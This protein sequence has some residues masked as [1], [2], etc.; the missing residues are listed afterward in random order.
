MI[1]RRLARSPET[2]NRS[3]CATTTTTRNKKKSC[4]SVLG[5]HSVRQ[6]TKFG[7]VSIFVVM[8]G[9]FSLH[10]LER[11]Q[12]LKANIEA[13]ALLESFTATQAKIESAL[14]A[15]EVRACAVCSVQCPAGGWFDWHLSSALCCCCCCC[16]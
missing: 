13:T 12:E 1:S 8:I 16:C 9:Q 2:K 6:T 3:R 4:F 11:G 7:I 5:K 15:E 10:D 14:T